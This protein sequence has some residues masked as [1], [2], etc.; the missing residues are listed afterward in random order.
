MAQNEPSTE[1]PRLASRGKP[2]MQE[3][4]LIIVILILGMFLWVASPKVTL[5]LLPKEVNGTLMP[6][7]RCAG[8]RVLRTKNIVDSVL[9]VMSWMAVMAIG[10][11]I[12][13]ISG[14][15]ILFR[16]GASWGCRRW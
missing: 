7:R 10:E 2:R 8:E 6:F 3:L 9:V 1:P 15:L 4:G 13:I 12:V 14:G 5:T 11:T 16:W